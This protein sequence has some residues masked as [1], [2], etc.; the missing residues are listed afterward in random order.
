MATDSVKTNKQGETKPVDG[1]DVAPDVKG[2]P[3]AA[4]AANVMSAAAPLPAGASTGLPAG[5]AAKPPAQGKAAAKAPTEAEAA[6]KAAEQETQQAAAAAQDQ[7]KQADE[8]MAA[9]TDALASDLAPGV[10]AGATLI[11][12]HEVV[13]TAPAASI[14][15]AHPSDMPTEEAKAEALAKE[16][17]EQVETVSVGV[18]QF[19]GQQATLWNRLKKGATVEALV[20]DLGWEAHQVM[21]TIESMV[22]LVGAEIEG[23]GVGIKRK[24]TVREPEKAATAGM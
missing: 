19:V 17:E 15:A 6:V 3:K 22:Q 12:G 23:V 9:K 21:A 16:A 10:A 14:N 4:T 13:D 24:F 8:E 7:V 1:I 5:D 18:H 20:E 2:P 11:A